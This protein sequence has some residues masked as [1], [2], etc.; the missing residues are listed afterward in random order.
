MANIL[1]VDDSTT[2]REE[3]KRDLEEAG[4]TVVEAEDG[5]EGLKLALKGNID[6]IISDLNMPKM[7]GLAMCS[8]IREQGINTPVFM[9]TTQSN[10]E[11]KA[12]ATR[13]SVKAWIV[14]PHNKVVLI[15]G[16]AK[17][18]SLT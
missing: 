9:L 16:L 11:L 2:F 1:V 12:E 8:H 3:L 14:K 15:K 17:V 18:L 7:D 10:P 13:L 6:L 5:E 4:Y